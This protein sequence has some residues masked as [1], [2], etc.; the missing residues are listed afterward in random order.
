MTFKARLGSVCLIFG[1]FA[2]DFAFA[3][4]GGSHNGVQFSTLLLVSATILA[5]AIVVNQLRS[6]L[7]QMPSERTIED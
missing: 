4:H 1:L 3:H 2:A 7:R 6:L 5:V